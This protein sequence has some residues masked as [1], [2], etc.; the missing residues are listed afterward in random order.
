IDYLATAN[1]VVTVEDGL[2]DGGIGQA[3]CAQL[4][5]EST[6]PAISIGIPKQFLTH[7]T[8]STW[9][10]ELGLD[11]SGIAAAITNRLHSQ[12]Q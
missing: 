12:V 7:K 5:A 6:G 2:V 4:A 8:R 9:L 1:M 3:I 11:G 10:A